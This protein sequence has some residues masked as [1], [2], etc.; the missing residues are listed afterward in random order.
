MTGPVGADPGL[1]EWLEGLDLEHDE[2]SMLLER[3]PAGTLGLMI[4]GSRARGD[5]LPV[6][7]FDLL[8]LSRAAS[9]TFKVRRVSVSSYSVE[10]LRS[11]T[12]T[13]FGTHLIRDGRILYDPTCELAKIVAELEPV[14][15]HVLLQTVHRYSIILNQPRGERV[16]YR[17]GLTRLA[18]YLLRTAVYARAMLGGAPCFSV[19]ELATRF[20]D[21]SLVTLLASDPEVTG[22]PS[23]E[24][25]DELTARLV[26]I[27]GPPPKNTYGSLATLAVAMWDKDRNL[28]ALAIRAA[29]EDE[30]TLDYS[31]LPKVLL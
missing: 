28:A 1:G 5:H 2:V 13:L 31:D 7:D 6:S 30:D 17:S 12:H 18:R 22:P 23:M 4:Y 16:A 3:L 11:A 26:A 19:R 10:Q 15:P 20:S 25:L 24:L 21:P 14:E 29:S 8:R 9:P 27:L